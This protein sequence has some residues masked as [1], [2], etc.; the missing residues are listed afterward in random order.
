MVLILISGRP[1]ILGESL[2]QAEAVMAAWLPGT[3]GGGIADI[4]FGEY[5]PTGT[6]TH[7]WP[8]DMSQVSL[9]VGD[10]GSEPLFPY[11]YGLQDWGT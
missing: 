7:S 8:V 6:L 4:L 10:E 11:G 1:M 5:T 3:E 2:D 9:N